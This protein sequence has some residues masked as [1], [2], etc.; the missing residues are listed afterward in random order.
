[1]FEVIR[2]QVLVTYQ[3]MV[4]I[5]VTAVTLNEAAIKVQKGELDGLDA[6]ALTMVLGI[7]IDAIDEAFA[8][9]EPPAQLAEAAETAQ[10]LN[11]QVKDVLAR[12][13]N[14]EI[15]SGQV[16]VELEPVLPALEATAKGMEAVIARGYGIDATELASIREEAVADLQEITEPSE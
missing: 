10:A 1:V 8:E 15:D 7:F 12:W 14:E 2:E 4:L 5:Q 6:W 3:Y 9:T 16:Q 11:E 13:F